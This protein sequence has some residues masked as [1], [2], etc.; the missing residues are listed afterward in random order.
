[1]DHRDLRVVVLALLFWLPF[2]WPARAEETAP[3]K[4]LGRCTI[5]DLRQPPYAEWLDAGYAAYT[6]DPEVLAALRKTGWDGV[7]LTLVLGTW[8]GDSRREVPRL[9]KLLD[10]SGF[11]PSR[12]R[13]IAVDNTEALHKRS[14]GGEEARLEIYRVPT[15]VVS[16]GGREV[17]RL[18]EYPVLS[19]ER[20]L[21]AIL[22]GGA[23]QPAYGS[24]PLVRRWLHE[25][26]L[27]DP[28]VSAAGLADQLRA[29]VA[30]EAEL[31]AAARVLASRGDLAEATKLMEVNCAVFRDSAKCHAHLADFQLRS[32]QTQ[33]AR[34]S[35]LRAL[36]RNTDPAEIEALVELVDRTAMATS[37]PAGSAE[38]EA[39]ETEL[40]AAEKK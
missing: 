6:P 35:V 22:E 8:C 34:A 33:R 19:L 40:R 9:L 18:V 24:Y 27:A 28:N 11:P 7:E 1:M 13:M 29:R 16:R 15:L 5:A 20:D 36:E 17:S 10:T 3:P 21:L 38:I 26:L 39:L 12:L 4:L 2:T 25:G 31:Y 32:G 37:A 23:Y 14:P 30:S